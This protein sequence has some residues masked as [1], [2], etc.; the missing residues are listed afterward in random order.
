MRPMARTQVSVVLAAVGALFVAPIAGGAGSAT[1]IVDRTLVCRP[2][3]VGYP[4]SVRFM[5]AGATPFRAGLPYTVS[6]EISVRNGGTAPGSGVSAGVRTG[7]ASGHATGAMWF[8]R[9]RCQRTKIRVPLSSKGLTGGPAYPSG[10]YY[11]C[12]APVTVLI[13]VRAVFKR[14]TALSRPARD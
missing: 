5:T 3:G 8:T 6:P 1:R 7:P 2:A 11:R 12:D 4:D 9:T 13:R 14:T 10:E